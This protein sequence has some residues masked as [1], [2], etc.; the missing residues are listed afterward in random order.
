MVV[1]CN[2]YD[3]WRHPYIP[4]MWHPICKKKRYWMVGLKCHSERKECLDYEPSWSKI[5]E[6]EN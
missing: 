6:R 4:D 2:N 5:G 1:M 3:V